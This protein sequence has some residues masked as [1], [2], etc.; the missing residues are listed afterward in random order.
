MKFSPLAPMSRFFALA[1]S[2]VITLFTVVSMAMIGHPP[3]QF[4]AVYAKSDAKSDAK[5]GKFPP[6][7][8]AATTVAH[9]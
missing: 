2:V 6:V 8:Q 3:E 1:G 5:S 9:R 7:A 4:G